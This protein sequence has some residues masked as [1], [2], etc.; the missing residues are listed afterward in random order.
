MPPVAQPKPNAPRAIDSPET[1]C[2]QFIGTGVS[3]E[4]IQKAAAFFRDE[5][6]ADVNR[7]RDRSGFD[8]FEAVETEGW[9]AEVRRVVEEW[10]R[11][12]ANLERAAAAVSRP[13]RPAPTNDTDPFVCWVRGFNAFRL[14][15]NSQGSYDRNIVL[16][17]LGIGT[18]RHQTVVFIALEDLHLGNG[19]FIDLEQGQDVCL[20]H[21]APVAFPRTG[22]GLG[23]FFALS[24]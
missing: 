2:A 15:E 5:A 18:R 12:D 1:R 13:C 4:T 16:E 7:A 21:R 23:I 3:A 10:I 14:L 22:G 8:I 11:N 19:F 24:L 6:A 20:D 17:G 9:V